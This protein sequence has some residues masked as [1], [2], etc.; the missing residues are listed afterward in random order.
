MPVRQSTWRVVLFF[1]IETL[2]IATMVFLLNVSRRPACNEFLGTCTRLSGH[3]LVLGIAA[4]LG[5]MAIL[6]ALFKMERAVWA[7]MLGLGLCSFFTAMVIFLSLAPLFVT[8]PYS[9]ILAV[10][11]LAAAALLGGAGL[12]GGARAGFLRLTRVVEERRRMR[13]L[14][15]GQP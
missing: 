4:V 8:A 15:P 6:A 11:H 3:G 9:W 7:A 13:P 5:E 12:I 14:A 1:L 10:W 2:A